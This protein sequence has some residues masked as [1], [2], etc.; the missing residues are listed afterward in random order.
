MAQGRSRGFRIQKEDVIEYDA[1]L[2]GG[3]QQRRQAVTTKIDNLQHGLSPQS[4][5]FEALRGV[6]HAALG[7]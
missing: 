5:P 6:T 3:R 4:V 7:C 1:A 2:K